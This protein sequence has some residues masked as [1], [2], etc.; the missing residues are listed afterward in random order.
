MANTYIEAILG[1]FVHVH[2]SEIRPLLHAFS[3]FF[4]LLSAYFVVLPLRDEAAISLGTSA[5]PMLFLASLVLTMLA[6]PAS[7]YLLS[8]PHLPKGRALVLLYRFFGGSLIFFFLLYVKRVLHSLRPKL[9]AKNAFNLSVWQD[10]SWIFTV[11]RASFFLW[12][13]L[14]NLF[15]ISA[16]WARVTDIMSSEAGTR[17]F[18]F[19]G[20]GATLGQLIG[21][22]LAVAMAHLGPVLLLVSALMMEMAARCA[23]SV[24]DDDLNQSSV[25]R[26]KRD[27]C[28]SDE[29]GLTHSGSTEQNSPKPRLVNKLVAMSEGLRLIVASTY[30][31]HIC[32]FLW[33]SAV[34]SSFFYFE[35]SAVVAGIVHDPLGRRILLAEINSLTAVFILIGQLTMTGRLLT[36]FG[37]TVALCALPMVAFLNLTALAASPSSAVVAISEATRKVINYV[38][39]R[40]AREILFTV[41][42]PEEKYKAKVCIDT[43]VQRL[44]DAAAAGVY[45]MME[46][47]LLE[48]PS[49][50]AISALPVC[51]GW[52][53]V[54]VSLGH[55]Q[56]TLAKMLETTP[57]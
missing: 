7:S 42:T 13:A 10:F 21:S 37:I 3:A 6:A 28:A 39:T 25:L 46:G 24:G 20:A 12:I 49:A 5:L 43:L 16:M 54:A 29:G 9:T 31:L 4:F 57:R 19:V 34:V 27:E 45:K 17:L 8:Y 51:V 15:T 50:V 35:K 2:Q 36:W 22:L 40:P 56:A 26:L 44:G 55:R 48:G 14:L 23:L 47:L 41:T 53:W 52:L 30:L 38:V 1:K 33:L 18:G 11:V 32:A